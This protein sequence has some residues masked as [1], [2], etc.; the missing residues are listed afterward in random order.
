M[1]PHQNQFVR[2]SEFDLARAQEEIATQGYTIARNLVPLQSIEESKNFWLKEYSEAK[3]RNRVIWTPY[4]GQGN[5]IGY[6]KDNF[7]CLFRSCDFLWNEPL[8]PLTR[9]VCIRL[10]SLRNIILGLD[11]FHGIKFSSN[12]YGIFVTTSYYPPNQGWLETH[13][14]GIAKDTPLLHHILPM[15][16]KGIDYKG[17][18]LTLENR[19]GEVIDVDSCLKPGD[20]L[21]Y[22]GALK[23]GVQRIIPIDGNPLGRLQMFAIPTYFMNAEINLAVAD[24]MPVRMFVGSRWLRL[25]NNARVLLLGKRSFIRY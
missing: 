25:K 3:A 5:A 24:K 6:S 4:L 20:V 13:S 9:E 17:G 23:H 11:P 12:R 22:D 7:Q 19:K 1:T 10:N 21:F 18:G 14:D 16:F 8:H 15:T 2:F